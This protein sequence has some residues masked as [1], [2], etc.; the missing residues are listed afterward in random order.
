MEFNANRFSILGK[1]AKNYIY[2]DARS[3]CHEQGRNPPKRGE[4]TN[5]REP[6]KLA[7]KL[8]PQESKLKRPKRKK[9]S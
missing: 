7:S 5:A 2:W 9:K 6:I 8:K 1:T 3:L 4:K